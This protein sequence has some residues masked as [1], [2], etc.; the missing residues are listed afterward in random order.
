MLHLI[1]L[2]ELIGGGT[3]PSSMMLI[4]VPHQRPPLKDRS[5]MRI[6][7]NIHSA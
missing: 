3:K 6:G 5:V 2:A 4:D 7:L 1:E